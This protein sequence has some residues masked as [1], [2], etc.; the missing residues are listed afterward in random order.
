MTLN[1]AT[2]DIGQIAT[3]LE[4]LQLQLTAVQE[5]VQHHDNLLLR[6]DMLEKE[7]ENLKKNLQ[8]R[9]LALE[10]LRAQ[11]LG[12][13][14]RTPI[15]GETEGE[16][17]PKGVTQRP[18]TDASFVTIARRNAHRPD[19][20]V[21]VKRKI[22]LGRIFKTVESKGPQGYQYVYIGRS[23]K[24]QRSEIRSTLRKAGVD[25]GRILDICFPASEVIGL[26]LHVQYVTEFTDLMKACQADIVTDFD[27]LDPKNIADPKYSNMSSNEREELMYEFTNTRCLQTLAFLRPLNVNGVGKYFVTEGW[28]CDED[29][30]GAVAAAMDRFAKK[31]PK[32]ANFL[33]SRRKITN[34]DVDPSAA[35]AMEQ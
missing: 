2:L 9:D 10:K 28:I 20:T 35:S 24:L 8:D 6:M 11:L 5:K 18:A 32:K 16:Q 3:V 13:T 26:L 31:E 21:Q 14:E 19:P 23:K 25:L 30:G 1:L 7:N 33:F 12:S 27:P 17:S 15:L 22:A 29:L 4:Q 34:D